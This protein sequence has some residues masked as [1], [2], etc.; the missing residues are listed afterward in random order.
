MPLTT[1]VDS[2]QNEDADN[3]QK[4][5]GRQCIRTRLA[6]AQGNIFHSLY[7]D[8]AAWR[9]FQAQI[10]FAISFADVLILT[11]YNDAGSITLDFEDRPFAVFVDVNVEV[12]GTTQAQ[13]MRYDSGTNNWADP[14]ILAQFQ[15]NN[16][17]EPCESIQILGDPIRTGRQYVFYGAYFSTPGN[18]E[19][20]LRSHNDD[21]ASAAGSGFLT[22]IQSVDDGVATQ[23]PHQQRGA[24][25]CIDSLGDVHMAWC[26]REP[27]GDRFQVYYR[28]FV[29]LTNTFGGVELVEDTGPFS[30]ARYFTKEMQ[31]TVDDAGTIHIVGINESQ[32]ITRDMRYWRKVDL[33][34]SAGENVIPVGSG[35]DVQEVALGMSFD[36][37]EGDFPF[38][39]Y[40]Q[41]DGGGAVDLLYSE[42]S[43]AGAWSGAVL[44]NT[45]TATQER[46][47]PQIPCTRRHLGGYI[48]I[49][50]IGTYHTDE[51]V[52]RVRFKYTSDPM[53]SYA[54]DQ[55]VAQTVEFTQSDPELFNVFSETVVQTV[56]FAQILVPRFTYERSIVQTV[57]FTDSGV[58]P[59]TE[60]SF[61][62]A[63]TVNFS[64]GANP[65]LLPPNPYIDTAPGYVVSPPILPCG[66]EDDVMFV[67]FIGPLPSL[68]LELQLKRPDFKKVTNK[69]YRV[70]TKRSRGGTI[71]QHIRGDTTQ[72][73][74]LPFSQLHRNKL[75][76][77]AD[78]IE[79][80][81]GQ[82]FYYDDVQGR[83]MVLNLISSRVAFRNESR[84]PAGSA[85][86]EVEGVFL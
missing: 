18:Y 31:I 53:L 36:P 27:V 35:N 29:T 47:N 30:D 79:G 72:I 7:R 24:T 25:A 19:V 75:E 20:R 52:D 43:A 40:A 12:P 82:Q 80:I 34:W 41:N 66:S 73:L 86:L 32:S 84:E 64:Q 70:T 74:S 38:V 49:G 26:N 55:A 67:F 71:R 69:E 44:V 2:F 63:Q 59:G 62:I 48:D 57:E 10:P 8:G 65:G 21:W 5:G 85:L 4:R 13:I 11:T 56:D 23:G 45:G 3:Y 60:Y 16:D 15:I 22:V 37:T 39:M 54:N 17:A 14:G 33:N 81:K 68:T 83:R 9:H 46:R 6:A 50:G 42:R 77:L 28:R 61:V 58:V 1:W 76:E 78:F 51:G